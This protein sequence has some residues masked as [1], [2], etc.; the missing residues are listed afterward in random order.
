[1]A[2]LAVGTAFA[3]HNTVLY[4]HRALTLMRVMLVDDDHHRVVLLRQ[5]LIDG[6]NAVVAQLTTS[7]VC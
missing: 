5:A 7:D 4:T 1:M 2:A 3:V 6:G